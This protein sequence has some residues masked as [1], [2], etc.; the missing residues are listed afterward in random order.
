MIV[1]V[2]QCLF[3]LRSYVSALLKAYKTCSTYT[4]MFTGLRSVSF[5]QMLLCLFVKN[6]VK[7]RDVMINLMRDVI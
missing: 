6:T 3:D 2:S 7:I 1:A 5:F 4:L